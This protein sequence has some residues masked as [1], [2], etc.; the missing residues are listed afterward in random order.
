MSNPSIKRVTPQDAKQ[1]LDNHP[2]AV[3]IDV[4]SRVEFDYVGHP[5]GAVHVP[6]KDYPAWEQN[7]DFVADV[8]AALNASGGDDPARPILAICRSGARSMA[9]A[10]VLADAGYETLFNVEEGF[11]G[12][13]DPDNHRGNINGWRFCGLPWEQS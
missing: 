9:A 5:I 4:R 1:V 2:D 7:P 6:W 3:L 10:E 11:E 13:K 8:R 12:D